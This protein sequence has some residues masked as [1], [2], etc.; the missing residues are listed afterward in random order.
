MTKR[1]I[2]EPVQITDYRWEYPLGTL[3]KLAGTPAQE[4]YTGAGFGL[5]EIEKETDKP[6]SLYYI[7][8]SRL[9]SPGQVWIETEESIIYVAV[10]SCH[11]ACLFG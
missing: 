5:V 3:Y 8:D 10:F 4:D 7:P 11:D 2:A 6:I 9:I 1:K